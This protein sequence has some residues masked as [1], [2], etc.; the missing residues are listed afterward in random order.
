[1]AHQRVVTPFRK[2]LRPH[3]EVVQKSKA[4]VRGAEDGRIRTFAIITVNPLNKVEIT[5]AGD[6]SDAR[7]NALLAGLLRMAIQ[8]TDRS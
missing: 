8:L 5:C 2:A 3:P 4:L 1:M 7:R 6:L